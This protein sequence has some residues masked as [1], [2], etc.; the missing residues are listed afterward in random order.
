MIK[1]AILVPIA[2]N[3][4]AIFEPS[5]HRWVM[6][7]A[8]ARFGGITREGIVEG[9]WAEDAQV[10]ED[11]LLRLVIALSS[12]QQIPAW[13]TFVEEIRVRFRQISLYGEIAGV[14]EIFSG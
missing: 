4:G 7:E 10:Y 14:P 11:R 6:T 2:N 3:N 13:L 8:V 5:D 12:W 9:Q 1:T